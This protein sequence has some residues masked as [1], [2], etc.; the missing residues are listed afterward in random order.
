MI[1]QT[2]IVKTII[3]KMKKYKKTDKN[4]RFINTLINLSNKMKGT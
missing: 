2:I 3:V 4:S 1:V